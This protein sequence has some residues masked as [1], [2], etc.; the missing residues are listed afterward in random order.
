MLYNVGGLISF[1]KLGVVIRNVSGIIINA[2]KTLI[3]GLLQKQ[4]GRPI[5]CI[6]RQMIISSLKHGLQQF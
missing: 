5:E 1:L 4:N 2:A 6:T 3:L